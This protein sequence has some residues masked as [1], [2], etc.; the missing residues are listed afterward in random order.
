MYVCIYGGSGV[1]LV[2]WLENVGG[3]VKKQGKESGNVEVKAWTVR[4]WCITVG[5][6]YVYAGIFL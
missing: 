6:L 4:Y 1:G 5:N 2:G 3:S